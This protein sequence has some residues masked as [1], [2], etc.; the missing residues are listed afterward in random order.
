VS[1]TASSTTAHDGQPFTLVN[2]ELSA[3]DKWVA[4]FVVTAQR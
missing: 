3:S 1:A 4:L 2:T